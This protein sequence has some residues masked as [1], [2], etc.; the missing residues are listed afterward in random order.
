MPEMYSENYQRSKVKC[1]AEI[2]N[3]KKVLLYLENG[4]ECTSGN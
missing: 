3:N 1:F 4:F 2:V